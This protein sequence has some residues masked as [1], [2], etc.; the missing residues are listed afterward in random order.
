[1]DNL[2]VDSSVLKGANTTWS[3]NPNTAHEISQSLKGLRLYA[4]GPVCTLG[5]L[6]L[7]GLC[8]ASG[9][10]STTRST[11]PWPATGSQL[12]SHCLPMAPLK[13]R[14]MGVAFQIG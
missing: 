3:H 5:P 14:T 8:T 11:R 10:S 1:M 13:S 7:A 4:S 2:H 9:R 6:T 12:R